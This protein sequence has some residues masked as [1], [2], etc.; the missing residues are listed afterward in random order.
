MY[1]NYIREATEKEIE[2]YKTIEAKF[3]ALED[4]EY[5]TIVDTVSEYVFSYGKEKKTAYNKVYRLAKKYNTTVSN[6]YDWYC[7]D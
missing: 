5:M 2:N 1:A 4:D 3:E 6:L 7:I